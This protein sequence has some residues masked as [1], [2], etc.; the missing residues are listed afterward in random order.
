MASMPGGMLKRDEANLIGFVKQ[1][2]RRK[3]ES[4]C[5]G[6]ISMINPQKSW[7]KQD[8][9]MIRHLGIMDA[10]GYWAGTA[11]VYR[12]IG[13][14]KLLELPLNVQDTAL[15]FPDRMGLNEKDAWELIN[16][17]LDNADK[18]G[19]VL[20]INWHDRSLAPERLW[21]DTYIRLVEHLRKTN[22]WIDTASQVVRWFDKRRS[23][24]FKDVC[25][26]QDS[27]KLHIVGKNDDDVPHLMVRIHEPKTEALNDTDSGGVK[28]MYHDIHFADVLNTEIPLSRH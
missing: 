21:G 1:Q 14:K 9:V 3:W 4:E 23:V 27:V 19:G 8:S 5:T 11:Q 22:A 16:T 26:L 10:V 13:V 28:E 6:Y 12:P 18:Y 7:K 17:L 15:F 2:D 24:V 20:T 25:F